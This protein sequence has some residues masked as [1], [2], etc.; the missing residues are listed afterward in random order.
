MITRDIIHLP[1]PFGHDITP[2]VLINTFHKLTTWEERY[3]QLIILAKKL[4]PMPESIRKK[5]IALRGCEN[6][7]WLE[8]QRL[9]DGT[10]HF[11]GDSESRIMRGF[12][13]VLFTSVEGKTPKE[14]AVSEPLSLFEYLNLSYALSTTRAIGLSTLSKWIL[15]ISDSYI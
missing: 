11:Y 7:I 15:A 5:E 3:Y 10:L 1:H 9:H 2:E 14:I 4:P 12:L 6:Q 13:A 8:H